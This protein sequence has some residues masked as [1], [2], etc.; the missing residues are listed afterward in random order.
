MLVVSPLDAFGV[1]HQALASGGQRKTARRAV[2][3]D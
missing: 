2:E 1:R 3:Q